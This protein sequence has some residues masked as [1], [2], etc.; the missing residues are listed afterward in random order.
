MVS[1]VNFVPGPNA[2]ELA[3]HVGQRGVHCHR[4]FRPCEPSEPRS[5]RWLLLPPTGSA[6]RP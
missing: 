3:I 5:S 6:A 4:R 2:T 1:A